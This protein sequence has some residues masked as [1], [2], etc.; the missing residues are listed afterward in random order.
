MPTT[1][2][3]KKREGAFCTWTQEEVS[4]LLDR[5]LESKSDTKLSELFC[6]HFSVLPNGNVRPDSVCNYIIINVKSNKN[7]NYL[8]HILGSSWRVIKSKYIN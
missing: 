3:T 5:P 8:I 1:D 2:S 6:W 7:I 4:N